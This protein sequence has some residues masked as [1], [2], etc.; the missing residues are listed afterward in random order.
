MIDLLERTLTILHRLKRRFVKP[1]PFHYNIE[2]FS[3]FKRSVFI[4]GW[5]FFAHTPFDKI[6]YSTKS[7]KWR[8]VAFERR[9]SDDVASAHNNE[10][11][12]NAR[13]IIRLVHD[14]SDNALPLKLLFKTKGGPFAQVHECTYLQRHGIERGPYRNFVPKFFFR[15]CCW[16]KYSECL[17]NWLESALRRKQ[18][19][20]LL[21]Q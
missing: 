6:Y 16:Q 17:R 2:A 11:G 1:Q 5:A 20:Y 14:F 12:Q 7:G 15:L 13:F 8:Q 18:P 9:A 10:S 3:E 21:T 4:S 19:H